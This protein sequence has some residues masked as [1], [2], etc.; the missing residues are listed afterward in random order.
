MQWQ[1]IVEGKQKDR[2][3]RDG[4]SPVFNKS[5]ATPGNK[6]PITSTISITSNRSPIIYVGVRGGRYVITKTGKKRYLKRKQ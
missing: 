4:C 2:W 3:E 1:T 5:A 6:Q